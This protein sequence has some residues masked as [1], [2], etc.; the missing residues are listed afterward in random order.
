MNATLF[1]VPERT[2]MDVF[3]LHI[4]SSHVKTAFHVGHTIVSNFVAQSI[5]EC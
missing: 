5:S 2:L 3:G 4:Y 1:K